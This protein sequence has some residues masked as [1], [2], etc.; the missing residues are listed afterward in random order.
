MCR[1]TAIHPQSPMKGVI[2]TVFGLFAGFPGDCAGAL[3]QAPEVGGPV[4]LSPGHAP[5]GLRHS[6]W[7]VPQFIGFCTTMRT[8]AVAMNRTLVT[9]L[10][11]ENAA[12]CRKY[13][14][15]EPAIFDSL[16]A[17]MTRWD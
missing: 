16:S 11:A 12:K 13:F 9:P 10:I 7:V 15:I 1:S 5:A 8:S 3:T 4:S 17:R 14:S 6:L 2:T